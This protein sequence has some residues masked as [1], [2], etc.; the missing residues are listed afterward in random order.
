MHGA[1]SENLE[2]QPDG[3]PHDI[4]WRVVFAT[5]AL[6]AISLLALEA[7]GWM[8]AV[9]VAVLALPLTVALLQR[10]SDRERDHIHPAR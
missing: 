5:C 8:M 1:M 3:V 4:V 7:A 9:I 10:K 6:A 2:R